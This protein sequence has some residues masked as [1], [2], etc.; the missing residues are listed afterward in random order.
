MD[1][2]PRLLTLDHHTDTSAPFRT[3]LRR[4]P[5]DRETLLAAIDVADEA[6]VQRAIDKLDKDEHIVTAL[7]VDV[8]SSAFVLAQNAMNTDAS[9]FAEHAI[10]CR[11]I[12]DH[13]W[14]HVLD[15]S[16][17]DRALAAFDA[18]AG[19]SVTE[20]PYILDIDLDVFKTFAS[21]APS[22]P[23]TFLRL[24]ANAELITVATEPEFVARLAVDEG[25]TS[26][27][28]L[29]ELRGLVG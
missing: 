11:E 9:V 6:S 16:V 23:S 19:A 25:L 18:I 12:A 27:F 7:A 5:G 4:N 24:V 21:V 14:D 10:A 26:A 13:E 22:D 3:W 20:G 1:R 28:L 8:V 2:A 17:L 29:R 15:A